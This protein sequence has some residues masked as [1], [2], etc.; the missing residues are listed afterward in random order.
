MLLSMIAPTIDLGIIFEI[1][2]SMASFTPQEPIFMVSRIRWPS[3]R[4]ALVFLLLVAVFFISAP[5]AQARNTY[6]YTDNVEGDPGDGVLRPVPQVEP[7]PIPKGHYLPVYTLTLIDMGNNQYLPIFQ[8]SDFS[9]TPVI[10]GPM[11]LQ[12]ISPDGR[13]H[14]AP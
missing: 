9:G 4:W 6:D 5:D 2:F 3:P 8:F 10:F 7:S 12:R 11:H 1:L 14:R 13:W